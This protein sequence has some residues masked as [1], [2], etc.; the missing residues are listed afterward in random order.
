MTTKKT[1]T[2][3]PTDISNDEMVMLVGVVVTVAVAGD[4]CGYYFFKVCTAHKKKPDIHT[5][6][7]HEV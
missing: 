6:T 1:P 7:I 2:N 4:D 5:S 3:Q